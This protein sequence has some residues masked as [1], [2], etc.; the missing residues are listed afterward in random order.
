[1]SLKIENLPRWSKRL[2]VMALDFSI[3]LVTV[4]LAY[5]LR[6][7]EWIIPTG[8]QWISYCLAP[9]IAI[10][11]FVFFGLYRGIFRFAG[12]ASF[13]S[14][15]SAVA[16]YAVIYSAI[17]MVYGVSG[18]PRTVG[19]I[20]PLLL[21]VFVGGVRAA[22]RVVL[23]HSFS[24]RS[25]AKQRRAV[26]F[27]AGAAGRQLEAALQRT[28]EM[29]IVAFVDDN[30]LL[31]GR[32][33]HGKP[34]YGAS[35][36][37]ELLQ[38]CRATD[39]LLAIPSSS[40]QRRKEIIDS[41][42]DYPVKIQTVPSVVDIASGRVKVSELRELRIEELLGRDT[43]RSDPNLMT[44]NT[45]RRT[46]L[47]TGAGGSI[48]SELC[49][50]IAQLGPNRLI[51]VEVSEFNLYTIHRELLSLFGESLDLIPLLGSVLDPARMDQIVSRW[52]P[53]TIYHAAAYKHVP[54]VEGN[55]AEGVQNNVLGTMTMARV[56]ERHGVRDFV[57]I[58]TDKAVRPTNVM[59][60]T[61]RLAEQ[62]LQARAAEKSKTRFSMVR[63]G[64][65]LGS[66]GSMVPLFRSQIL[67]GGPVT[68]THRDIT[69]YF[70]TIPEASQ[71]VIQAGAMAKGG[72]VFVLDM[73]EP[74]KVIDIARR[75]IKLMGLIERDADHPDGDISIEV[76]GLRPGEKL[77]EELLIGNNPEKTQ[78]RLIMK[79]RE[80]FIDWK[81]LTRLLDEIL[82]AAKAGDESAILRLLKQLVPDYVPETNSSAFDLTL[83][84]SAA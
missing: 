49:R 69:R 24:P 61:K 17:F 68:I 34:I 50:Q 57:L 15:T 74:I 83:S 59:G 53:D 2:L 29:D 30:H 14:L 11:I 44:R 10:P 21:L 22:A 5:W 70:M 40:R 37:S 27:G 58:S 48:G 77:Y 67:D 3:C 20:Q 39:L 28:H 16:W 26:I 84:R 63:F 18:I 13:K 9:S 1:M 52:C 6:L 35:N 51:L 62:I 82:I 42:S 66:S 19:I 60:A 64:N 25:T 46:V 54:L 65:V 33:L 38:R 81:D 79:A 73:G 23:A 43:V 41:L 71:L 4:Q 32:E 36:L 55:I 8:N 72:E 7:S 56:A 75:M 80:D 47:V 78:H 45:T 76:I 12:W 31:Q